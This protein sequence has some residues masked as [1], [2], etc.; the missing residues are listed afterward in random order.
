MPPLC[1][2]VVWLFLRRH[3]RV[4]VIGR[5]EVEVEVNSPVIHQQGSEETELGKGTLLDTGT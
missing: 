2:G 5:F 1:E 3:F 4:K